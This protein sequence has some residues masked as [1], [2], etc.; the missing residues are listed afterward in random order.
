M[1]ERPMYSDPADAVRAINPAIDPDTARRIVAAVLG[2]HTDVMRVSFDVPAHLLPRMPEQAVEDEM[3]T[4]HRRLDDEFRAKGVLPI[5]L[6]VQNRL[7]SYSD[8]AGPL[9][10]FQLAVRVRPAKLPLAAAA[11]PEW[12][13][14]LA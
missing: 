3:V 12:D 7:H 5:E 10:H 6:P 14:T 11:A 4:L 1:D 8:F 2:W 9:V 13:P